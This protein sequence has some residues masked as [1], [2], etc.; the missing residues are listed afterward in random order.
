MR[1]SEECGGALQVWKGA[2]PLRS[3]KSEADQYQH[4]RRHL[5][6]ISPRHAQTEPASASPTLACAG[7]APPAAHSPAVSRPV[8]TSIHREMHL[9]SCW[10]LPSSGKQA[11]RICCSSGQGD[12]RTNKKRMRQA[13][14]EFVACPGL[15]TLTCNVSHSGCC[16]QVKSA[17]CAASCAAEAA[18][19]SGTLTAH[20]LL[21]VDHADLAWR[22]PPGA[23]AGSA[24]AS[25]PDERPG[26]SL[27][28]PSSFCG[29]SRPQQRS[30]AGADLLPLQC[31]ERISRVLLVRVR[32]LSPLP[33]CAGGSPFPI[34]D[35]QTSEDGE[36]RLL[37]EGLI[38]KEL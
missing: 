30:P 7:Q 13:Q 22:S 32:S 28:T 17:L 11:A 25:S 14:Q 23:Q 15:N 37:S 26:A 8:L 21:S 35:C 18:G 6:V 10:P 29:S 16:A 33:V 9:T 3:A 38:A 27:P 31:F 34:Q 2:W 24:V 19:L 1:N 20:S 12:I 4:R 36:K 5:T